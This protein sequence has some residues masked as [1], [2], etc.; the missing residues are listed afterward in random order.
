MLTIPPGEEKQTVVTAWPQKENKKK[1]HSTIQLKI[2]RTAVITAKKGA[3]TMW[4]KLKKRN[5]SKS[6]IISNKHGRQQRKGEAMSNKR[7]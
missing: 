7:D 5:M 1:K 2:T 4:N 3:N 6:E